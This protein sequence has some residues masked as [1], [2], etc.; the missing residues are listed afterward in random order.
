MEGTGEGRS[1]P[2]RIRATME[3]QDERL[4]SA[5]CN[6][7]ECR[8]DAADHL[9]YC[10]SL[11]D[12]GYQKTNPYGRKMCRTPMILSDRQPSLGRAQ[13]ILS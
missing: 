11:V 8:V 3:S 10:G 4:Q 9:Q 12:A 13:F 7:S 2:K 1:A 5:L 6:V